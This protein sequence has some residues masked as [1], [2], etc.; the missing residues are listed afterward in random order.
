MPLPLACAP[1]DVDPR[2]EVDAARYGLLMTGD[3]GRDA[4]LDISF[5]ED[6]AGDVCFLENDANMFRGDCDNCRSPS[7]SSEISNLLR[8]GGSD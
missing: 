8:F 5:G 6:V 2:V 4:W 7:D 1:V 3:L